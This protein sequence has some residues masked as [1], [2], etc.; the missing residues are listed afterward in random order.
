MEL[1]LQVM[2]L[3]GGEHAELSRLELLKRNDVDQE[4]A[5]SVAAHPQ[6]ADIAHCLLAHAWRASV[7][8]GGRGGGR[9]SV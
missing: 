4:A 5:G 1:A 8:G 2:E 3:C 9:G 6:I 7:L